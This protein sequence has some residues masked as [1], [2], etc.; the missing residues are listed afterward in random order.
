MGVLETKVKVSNAL[1]ISKKINKNW[2]WLFN[3]DRHYNGRIWV[4]WNPNIWEV[5]LH[6]K[7]VQFITCN[8]RLIEKNLNII[9]TFVYAFNDAIDR[10]QLW[11]YITS[12]CSSPLPWTFLGNFNCITSLNKVL[13]GRE[14]WIHGMQCF[15]DCL[16]NSGLEPM[17]TVGDTYTCTN[18]RLHGPVFKRLDRMV[19]NSTWFNTF[20]EDLVASAWSIHCIGSPVAQFSARLKHTKL[21]LRK[22]NRDHG[23]VHNQSKFIEEQELISK[24]NLDLAQEE[25]LLL[26]KARVR[27]LQLG[28]NNNSFFHKKCKVNWNRSKV[29]SLQDTDGHLVNGQA[30]CASVAVNYFSQLLGAP[31]NFDDNVDLSMVN[32]KEVNVEQ[33]RLLVAPVNDTHIFDTI[34]KMKKNKAPR[35]DGVNVEFFLAT[36][37]ITA[38]RLKKIMPT[39]VDISQSAFIPGRSIFDNILLAQELFRGYERETGVP[40]CALKIDLHKAFDSVH[41]SFILAVLKRMRFPNI[42][43]GVGWLQELLK[44]LVSCAIVMLTLLVGLTLSIPRGTF[45]VK[46]LGVPLISYQL[47]VNDCM[48]LIEKITSRLHSWA[49]LLLSPA[50]RVMLIK[51]IVHAIEAF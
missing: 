51:S 39:L 32:C 16:V 21:L 31:A 40:K 43:V 18:K 4:G 20:T 7:S 47:C 15:K 38:S 26:Q 24:L 28:D 25:S 42:M 30:S 3:Y 34:K 44:V 17:R 22:F 27:W 48:P 45:P 19:A 23:N 8:A 33:S 13:G 12:T 6:S 5:S 50:G 41:W 2:Q 49:T 46:F 11:E 14:H 9:V 1:S 29:L 36:W 35:P 10:V 37:N